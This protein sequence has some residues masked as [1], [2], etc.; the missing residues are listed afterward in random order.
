MKKLLSI[1]L[2]LLLWA[3]PAFADRYQALV[4]AKHLTLVTTEG[5]TYY[6]I[7]TSESAATMR[8]N[9]TSIDIQGDVFDV[10]QIGQMR[11]QTIPRFVLD[12]D[13]LTYGR[14]YTVS[15][16]IL[17]LRRTL[18]T[19]Q[20]NSIV[21]PVELNARQVRDA[22]GED[23]QLARVKGF[24]PGENAVVDYETIDLATDEAVMLA[25]YHYIIKPSR[26]PDL[27]E[28]QSVA[29]FGTVRPQA[30]F[31]LI[32]DVTMKKGESPKIEMFSSDDRSVSI[33]QQGTYTLK[34]GSASGNRKVAPDAY[35]LNDEGVFVQSSDSLSAKAFGSWLVFRGEQTEPLRFYIDGISDELSG[36]DAIGHD[37]P[38]AQSVATFDLQ[39]R[40]L[41]GLPQKR[42]IYIVNG[43]KH[44][45][46]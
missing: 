33:V 12:E 25:N 18:K 46:R 37:E 19:N 41:S 22:F 42:G 40:K 10:S 27:A 30:P 11:L 32:T 26:E 13:S 29:L 4:G 3:A 16:A 6:Y 43:R 28:G 7:L 36:I 2:P 20:W 35:H 34:D 15:H 14:N 9:G 39:G 44:Y 5:Y 1:F 21:L 23:A 24:R 31:Y 8:L 45:V 17:A 38:E